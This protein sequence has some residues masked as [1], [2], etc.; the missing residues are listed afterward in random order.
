M[1]RLARIAI[2]TVLTAMCH[3]GSATAD[4][5]DCSQPQTQGPVPAASDC[6]AILRVAV[7]LRTCDPY[8]ACICAPKGSLPTTATDALVCLRVVVGSFDDPS[9]PCDATTTT[10]APITTTTPDT[11]T[12]TSTSVTTTTVHV[13]TTTLAQTTTTL[14]ITTTTTEVTT[15]TLPAPTTTLAQPTTTA[16]LTT[17]TAAPTTT[18]A[19]PTT[20]TTLSA[21]DLDNDGWASTDGDCCELV[22][23][24]CSEPDQV[25]PGA[26]DF[27]GDGVD[28]DCNG[29]ADDGAA[30][31]DVALA[32]NSS[33]PI[34]YAKALGLCTLTTQDVPL[35]E[36]RAGLISAGFSLT[37]GTGTPAAASRS[38][39]PMFGGVLPQQGVA[40]VVLSTGNAAAPG[41]TNPNFIAFEEGADKD[42]MSPFPADW[43]EANGG[44]VPSTT[45][46]PSSVGDQALDPVMLELLVRVPTNARSLSLNLNFLTAEFPEWICTQYHDLFVVLLDSTAAGNPADENLAVYHSPEG[47]PY[48]VGAGLAQNATGLFRQC[49]N[50]VTGCERLQSTSSISTCIGQNELTQSGFD[51]DSDNGCQPGDK[52]GGGTG[53]LTAAGNVTP[54]EIA[55][56][57]IAIW[58]TSDPY[59]DSVAV[60]DNLRWS[61]AATEAGTVP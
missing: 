43:L 56:L 22:T 13:T 20:T 52:V 30:V 2:T 42:T 51:Q 25:N 34:D 8:P 18:T 58:D 4:P 14:P 21:Q 15:T 29:T 11:T 60:I 45:N 61:R 7:A 6:L 16:G 36:R 33:N 54:G 44:E 23:D 10:L 57:R 9:C 41:Q 35:P 24:G 38:I 26:F 19:A 47:D 3:A 27:G 59:F 53:W 28:D 40:A 17:T 49:R 31:C 12:T 37:D 39:R 32:S 46:C 1:A 5:G 50:G 48:L 55:R